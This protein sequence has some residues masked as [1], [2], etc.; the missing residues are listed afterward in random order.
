MIQDLLQS[1]HDPDHGVYDV[2]TLWGS[3]PQRRQGR[4]K[5]TLET[6][7]KIKKNDQ[8]FRQNWNCQ[9]LFQVVFKSLKYTTIKLIQDDH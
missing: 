2:P 6:F 9:I 1:G 7:E 8:N 4:V 5:V 3:D